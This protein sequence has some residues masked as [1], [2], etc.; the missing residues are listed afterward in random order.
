MNRAIRPT[1]ATCVVDDVAPD[2]VR[3]TDKERERE[4]KR[5][6]KRER[7]R[8]RQRERERET[9]SINTLREGR[10]SILAPIRSVYSMT[11][12][13]LNP[14]PQTPNPKPQTLTQ[15]VYTRLRSIDLKP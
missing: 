1:V 12:E 2:R 15:G 7:E 10:I 8:E 11:P 5:D 3:E 13:I 6:K 9:V 4:K 14:K